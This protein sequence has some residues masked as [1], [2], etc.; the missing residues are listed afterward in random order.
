MLGVDVMK[1]DCIGDEYIN[2]AASGSL[3]HS[4]RHQITMNRSI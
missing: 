3:S 1:L 4:T 2:M